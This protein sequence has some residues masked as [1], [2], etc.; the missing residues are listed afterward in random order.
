M[1]EFRDNLATYLLE[2]DKPLAI[3]RH[4]DTTGFFLPAGPKRTE[5][6]SAAFKEAADRWQKVLDAN[7]LLRAVFGI[8]V[9][10]LLGK[11]G[12]SVDFFAPEVCFLDAKR[13][14]PG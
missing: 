7:I 2:S 3:T 4:G 1:R 6:D 11:Y 5:A 10:D 9:Q 12:R 13:W 8:R 14:I